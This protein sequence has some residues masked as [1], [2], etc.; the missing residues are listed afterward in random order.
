[1]RPEA[2]RSRRRQH[3]SSAAGDGGATQPPAGVRDARNSFHAD[4]VLRKWH[5]PSRCPDEI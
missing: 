5:I 1:M 2:C 4:S 3:H